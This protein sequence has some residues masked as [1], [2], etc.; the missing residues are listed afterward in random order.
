M[1][2][3]KHGD[4]LARP[5]LEEISRLVTYYFTS[6]RQHIRRRVETIELR[7]E[8]SARRHLTT[9]VKLPQ[10]GDASIPWRDGTRLFYLPVAQ[11]RKR[12]AMTNLDFRDEENRS[13]P[14]LGRLENAQITSTALWTATQRSLVLDGRAR[15]LMRSYLRGAVYATEWEYQEAYLASALGVMMQVRPLRVTLQ[16]REFLRLYQL[17]RDLAACTIVWTGIAGHPGERRVIK[18]AYDVAL[19]LPGLSRPRHRAGWTRRRLRIDDIERDVSIYDFG[20]GNERGPARR[21]WNTF[22]TT[23][24]WAAYDV[25]VD[26][27]Y[28][29]NCTSY[30]LQFTAPEGVETREIRLRAQLVNSQGRRQQA[31]ASQDRRSAH[32]YFSGLRVRRDGPAE[33]SMRVGRRGFLSY[34]TASAAIIAGMLQSYVHW[35]AGIAKHEDVAA[36]ILLLVPTLL[37]VFIFRPSEHHL[38]AR[39][40]AGVRVVLFVEGLLSAAA[41]TVLLGALP[42][43]LSSP[44]E[45]WHW[46]A[47]LATA[48]A[49]ILVVSWLLALDSVERARRVTRRLTRPYGVYWSTS[50]ALGAGMWL[51]LDRGPR[52]DGLVK[53]LPHVEFTFA[54]TVLGLLAAWL[55]LFPDP[56]EV[57]VRFLRHRRLIAMLLALEATFAAMVVV[58][59][60]RWDTRQ[61]PW[62]RVHDVG[63]VVT[64]WL[65]LAFVAVELARRVGLP[66]PL[67]Q[68]DERLVL[69][70]HVRLEDAGAAFAHR[71]VQPR[72]GIGRRGPRR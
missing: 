49:A 44:A 27:L 55:L 31:I 25:A 28:L 66:P 51:L 60:G 20:D 52:D 26:S 33:I 29:R 24:G 41:A 72:F 1:P 34:A 9:D 2:D 37:A 4:A 10:R 53:T 7:D 17:W 70:E 23:V 30:H 54:V 71:I 19:E 45:A 50:V 47:L 21:M 65:L 13:L 56:P 63:R 5:T 69:D 64:L 8:R 62:D 6:S 57:P 35:N 61:V 12:P 38:A 15:D 32:L 14:L 39:M 16:D 11:I 36:A 58:A 68:E 18:F 3:P 42:F 59:L 67:Q 48:F 46:Y 40:L 22:A 43:G